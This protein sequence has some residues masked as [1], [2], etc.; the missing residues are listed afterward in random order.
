MRPTYLRRVTRVFACALMAVNSASGEIEPKF[1]NRSLSD[2]L[3]LAD[4]AYCGTN[5]V[6]LAQAKH[7]IRVIGTNALPILLQKLRYK[8]SDIQ[9]KA[10]IEHRERRL[11]KRGF[12]S[13][14]SAARPAIPELT[15]LLHADP[16]VSWSSAICLSYIGPETLPALTNALAS[17]NAAARVGAAAVLGHMPKAG[18][19]SEIM[20]RI[21]P[22][23]D[24]LTKDVDPRIRCS[25]A[26]SLAE[27]G[28]SK[29][30][31]NQ[32]D[33]V[34]SRLVSM[35]NDSDRH[36]RNAVAGGIKLF[37]KHAAVAIPHLEK[38][39]KDSCEV[40]RNCAEDSIAAIRNAVEASNEPAIEPK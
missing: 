7:A 40:V 24:V 31:I 10:E 21:V 2:W 3:M 4:S 18:F 19:S 16:E 9:L 22:P 17:S 11:A 37:G 34:V 35:M 8:E 29:E 36:V 15:R 33:G 30:M 38:L 32:S 26:Y 14:G 5:Y 28:S 13:L 27:I 23:L 20:R 25:A 1:E 6:L 39:T 12:E